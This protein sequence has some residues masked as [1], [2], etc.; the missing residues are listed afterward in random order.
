MSSKLLK[1]SYK[2]AIIKG[3]IKNQ[4]L[5]A[6]KNHKPI[7]RNINDLKATKKS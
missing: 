4:E 6:I 5:Q 7:G 1:K 2:L 3:P